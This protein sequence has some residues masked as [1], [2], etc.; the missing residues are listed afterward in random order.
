MECPFKKKLSLATQ[1]PGTNGEEGGGRGGGSPVHPERSP[2]SPLPSSPDSGSQTP[3]ASMTSFV[4]EVDTTAGKRHLNLR[5]LSEG[6]AALVFPSV[7]RLNSRSFSTTS[8]L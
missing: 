3:A 8:Y 2:S 7:S 6:V 1:Q 4:S 5:R